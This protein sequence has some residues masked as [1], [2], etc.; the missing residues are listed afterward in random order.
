MSKSTAAVAPLTLTPPPP[1]SPEKTKA[2]LTLAL[3]KEGVIYQTLIQEC[4]NVVFTKDNLGDE[5]TCL[6]LLRKTKKQLE[7]ADNPYTEG[8]K[9]WN[10]VRKSL[11]D[12]II[13]LLTKKEQEYS[14][15]ARE[16]EADRKKADEEKARVTRIKADIDTTLLTQSQLISGAETIKELETIEKGVA[17]LKINSGRFAEFLPDFA[18]R[19]SELIPFIREQ[20]KS[21]EKMIAL[22]E[23][24]KA[25]KKAG[26]DRTLLKIMGQKETLSDKMDGTKVVVQETAINSIVSSPTQVAEVVAP[27]AV[28][29]RRTSWEVEIGDIKEIMKKAPDLLDV[30]LNTTKAKVVL[31]TLKESGILDG[32]T[33]YILNGVRYYEKK[34]Y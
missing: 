31:K 4:E 8:W 26:D 23:K 22:K 32:K 2:E 9:G 5:R 21:I 13:E 20:K 16:I 25:A 3:S 6:V 11:L 24:E 10:G 33:E 14:K 19:A 18:S 28:S 15:L 27:E 7:D 30:N 29:A 34:I 17:S 1:F 12:P